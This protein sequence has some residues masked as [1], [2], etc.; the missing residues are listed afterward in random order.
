[1]VFILTNKD[2]FEP[3]YNDLKFTVRN[4]N[5]V[6][7]NLINSKCCLHVDTFQY[8]FKKYIHA[9]ICKNALIKLVYGTY[10]RNF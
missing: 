4:C 10:K 2:L 1:M 7:T 8:Q 6:S 5:Y 3:S 9:F